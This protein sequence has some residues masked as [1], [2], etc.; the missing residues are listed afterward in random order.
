MFTQTCVEISATL[1]VG[2]AHKEKHTYARLCTYVRTHFRLGAYCIFSAAKL[3]HEATS[4]GIVN[5]YKAATRRTSRGSTRS[6]F[7][8]GL[9]GENRR[10]LLQRIAERERESSLLVRKRVIST[11]LRNPIIPPSNLIW[12]D[13]YNGVV[14][15]TLV[16]PNRLK[17]RKRSRSL[18]TRDAFYKVRV[19][20]RQRVYD[21]ANM[22]VQH[23]SIN[24]SPDVEV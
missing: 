17:A 6:T 5:H 3:I 13:N 20:Y 24:V 22:E 18:V 11:D 15:P 8:A 23:R 10:L 21:P 16:I 1:L 4:P 14:L 19:G 9:V 7:I 2:H 12:H